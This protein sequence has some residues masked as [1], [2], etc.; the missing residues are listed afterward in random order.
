MISALTGASAIS[1]LGAGNAHAGPGDKNPSTSYVPTSEKGAA[2][3]VATLD[4]ESKI[5]SAQ[6]PDLSA[7]MVPRWKGSTAYNAGDIVLSPAGDTV[8][9]IGNFT[10]GATYNAAN[11]NLS[12]S[13]TPSSHAGQSQAHGAPS[14]STLEST[15]GSRSKVDAHAAS[16]TAHT[17]LAPTALQLPINNGAVSDVTITALGK[18]P[19]DG[20]TVLDTANG[21]QWTRSLGSWYAMALTTPSAF[22]PTSIPSLFAWYDASQI[23]G[24]SAGDRVPQWDDLSG[25]NHH[26]VQPNLSNMATY[27][28]NQQNGKPAVEFN[29]STTNFYCAANISHPFTVFAVIRFAASRAANQYALFTGSQM[30][31]AS[32]TPGTKIVA[33]ANGAGNSFNAGSGNSVNDGTAKVLCMQFDPSADPG[34]GGFFMRQNGVQGPSAAIANTNSTTFFTLGSSGSTASPTNVM[35]GQ[36]YEVLIYTGRLTSAQISQVESYLS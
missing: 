18:K 30:G 6:L 10:S 28:T 7:T 13:Y 33:L 34:T 17:L 8:S 25:Y 23:N 22:S 29:G 1:T 20:M 2:S 15:I 35:N 21:L 31:F 26:L 36:I 14:G 11:W 32:L 5:P 19:A 27:R 24:I 9:A 16:S 12:A 4:P 3:G